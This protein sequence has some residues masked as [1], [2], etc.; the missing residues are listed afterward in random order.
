MIRTKLTYLLTMPF[1]K[2]IYLFK[3]LRSTFNSV[4]PRV[5]SRPVHPRG[6]SMTIMTPPGKWGF[7]GGAETTGQ[8]AIT[9]C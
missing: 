3:D 4:S 8:L 6:S 9:L 7:R 2:L 1:G 5:V